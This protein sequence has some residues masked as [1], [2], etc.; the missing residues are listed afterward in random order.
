MARLLVP[1]FGQR[2]V[3]QLSLGVA[4]ELAKNND[5]LI[6]AR[7]FHR[8]LKDIIPLVG[9]GM[10]QEVI[11]QV[12][13][14]A[15][16]QMQEQ[17]RKAKE[18]FD[19]WRESEDIA[20]GRS[21]RTG[22]TVTNFMVTMGDYTASVVSSARAV[23]IVVVVAGDDDRARLAEIALLDA[24]RPLLLLPNK[25][26]KS[27]GKNI[28]IAWNGSAEAARAVSMSYDMLRKAKK[29][30]VVTVGKSANP[31][32]LVK[33]LKSNGIRATAFAVSAAKGGASKALQREAAKLNADMIVIGAYSHSRIR[34]LILGGVTLDL[35]D[36]PPIPTLMVH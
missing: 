7:L 21:A 15:R 34:E 5:A 19:N 22:R 8:D 16:E 17:T 3:D 6:E 27:I 20:N 18:S 26:I 11:E 29:V 36:A 9:E 10:S 35:F 30:S 4:S 25:K 14:V 13:N 28:V 33:M 2:D 1:T 31:A 24:Q 32:D 12:Q 23:D